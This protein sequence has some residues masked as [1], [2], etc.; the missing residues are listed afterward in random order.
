VDVYEL[1]KAGHL[2]MLE[3]WQ[4]FCAGVILGA[5]GSKD[6]LPDRWSL[7]TLLEPSD[8]IKDEE[9]T[10]RTE[11]RQSPQVQQ[12]QGTSSMSEASR[13]PESGAAKPQINS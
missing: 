3:N 1:S 6:V 12:Q 10:N 2:L 4:E 9:E 13:T 11:K 8:F 5:G 7:P